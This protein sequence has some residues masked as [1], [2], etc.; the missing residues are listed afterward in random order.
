MGDIEADVVVDGLGSACPGPLMDLV[1]RLKEVESGTV[2]ELKTEDEGSKK[3]VPD[4]LDQTDH[5][6]VDIIE[7]D[8]YWSIFVKKA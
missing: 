5:E 6:L 3:D 8:G 4:W 2:L 7:R 1:G